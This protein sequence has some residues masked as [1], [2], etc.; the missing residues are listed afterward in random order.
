MKIFCRM[1][2]LLFSIKKQQV[3]NGESPA[4]KLEKAPKKY[5]KTVLALLSKSLEIFMLYDGFVR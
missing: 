4:L 2:M 3:V 5:H 1:L